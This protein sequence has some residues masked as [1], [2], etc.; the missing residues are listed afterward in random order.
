MKRVPGLGD[1]APLV[2]HDSGFGFGFGF[3]RLEG[4]AGSFGDAA[5]FG[6]LLDSRSFQEAAGE[7]VVE[8]IVGVDTGTRALLFAVR[9]RRPSRTS[10]STAALAVMRATPDSVATAS[11]VT[12]DPG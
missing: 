9:C 6:E 1:L 4:L 10:R 7:V 11:S 8:G 5:F 2:V 12:G 3:E